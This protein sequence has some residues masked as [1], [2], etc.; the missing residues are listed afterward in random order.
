MDCRGCNK[1]FSGAS[2]VEYH[3]SHRSPRSAGAQV[4]TELRCPAPLA[5]RGT[6]RVRVIRS[7]VCQDVE[8]SALRRALRSHLQEEEKQAAEADGTGL[9]GGS[10]SGLLLA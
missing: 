6:R 5:I 8:T 4:V 2:G 1:Y 10:H 9:S 7:V 3:Q